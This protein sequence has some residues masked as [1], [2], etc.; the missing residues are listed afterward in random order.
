MSVL[1]VLSLVV[2]GVSLTLAV[3]MLLLA[4]WQE[5]RT[6]LNIIAA[7]FT[8]WVAVWFLGV[9]I[10]RVAAYTTAPEVLVQF[11]VR[12]LETGMAL[13]CAMLYLLVV[14]LTGAQSRFFL[15]TALV[16]MLAI[17][18]FQIGV[19][20]LASG[21]QFRITEDGTLAYG[22]GSALTLA[23]SFAG[24][25]GAAV[26][27]WQRRRKLADPLYGWAAA[28]FGAAALVELISPQFRARGIPLLVGAPAVLLLNYTLV[29]MQVIIP[30]NGRAAQLQGFRDVGLAIS[31][32]LRLDEVLQTIAREAAAMLKADGAAIFLKTGP[33]LELAA[34]HNMPV[35]FV[36]HQLG[37]GEGLSSRVVESG[38]LAQVEDYRRDWKGVPDMEY[39]R[40]AFG[41]VIAAPL[42]FREDIVG[43]LFVVVGPQGK[44]FDRDDVRLLEMLGP[45]AAVAII[46]SRLFEQQQ[47]LD[48]MKNQMI[49]MTSHDLKNPLFAAMS[50]IELLQEEGEGILTP[51]MQSDIQV[52]WTQLTRMERIIRGILD[53]ERV[54]S[55]TPS[56]QECDI[57]LIVRTAAEEMQSSADRQGVTLEAITGDALPLII[58]DA[59][60]IAQ[61]VANLVENAIKFTRTG[62][63]VTVKV[64]SDAETVSITVADTGVGIPAEAQ[65]RIFD[66]FFRATHPGM[67][68]VSGTGLG[69][70]LVKAV[71]DAHEGRV[72][73]ESEVGAGTVFHITLPINGPKGARLR[74]LD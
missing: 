4:L 17:T 62:G 30:L 29:K 49:R 20:M 44:R 58:G 6:A 5:T 38:R 25:F 37:P 26:V 63:R 24:I 52:T 46:N 50:H 74:V 48:R 40:Q 16:S 31:S 1:N 34:V 33:T 72:W 45:Q 42:V 43:V 59:H 23:Y 66:R 60:Y 39:A 55:G 19:T 71:T 10:G 56:Y 54:Q 69:L 32:R 27:L 14:V 36:G 8:G 11:S 64:T 41:S 15:R 28:L 21:G 35:Q 51:T 18:A 22:Y 67:E 70:S 2:G 7:I 53:L 12:L 68:P 57:G 73:L 47:E 3:M 61:A 65:T 9:L 13:S